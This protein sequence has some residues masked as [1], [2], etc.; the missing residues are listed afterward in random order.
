MS[1]YILLTGGNGFVG[2]HVAEALIAGGYRVRCLLRPQSR[3][4]WIETLP[5]DVKRANY[6]DAHSLQKVLEGCQAI[7]HFGGATKASDWEGYFRANTWTTQ[8]LLDAATRACPNLKLFLLCS[9]QAALGPSPSLDPLSEDAPPQPIT[10]Y[11]HSKLAAEKIC[12]QYEG[13]LPVVILRPPAIYGPR[14]RDIFIFFKLIRW[15]LAP[16]IGKRDRYFSLAHVADVAGIARL[17]LDRFKGEF[18]IYH[19][20]DGAIHRWSEVSETIARALDR[21]PIKIR[22]P[23]GL[24][25]SVSRVMS[26]WSTLAGRVATLNRDKLDDLLQQ[27]WLISSRRAEEELGFH[28]TY[29]LQTGMKMTVRWYR[30]KGWL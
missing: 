18:R 21:R 13:R 4:Q 9:S 16:T 25:A 24:A 6:A 2:S 17:I 15:W 12:R 29:D 1:D 8:A 23:L 19:V 3:P 30:E 22:V 14:D 10:P 28:P 27:Y 20:T 11:G 7:L 5:V 26:K